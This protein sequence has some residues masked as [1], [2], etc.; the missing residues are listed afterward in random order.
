MKVLIAILDA[1]FRGVGHLFGNTGEEENLAE[2]DDYGELR[3]ED[4]EES[5]IP[6]QD[7]ARLTP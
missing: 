6:V 2:E 3:L 4:F 1:C 5:N 7:P